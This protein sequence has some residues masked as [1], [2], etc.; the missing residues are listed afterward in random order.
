MNKRVKL[1]LVGVVAL[2]I[3]ASTWAFFSSESKIEN[4]LHTK[5]YGAETIEKFQPEQEL[6]P[7]TVIIKEVGVKNT[8]DYDLVVRVKLE[9]EWIRGE[10]RVI[11]FD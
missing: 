2:V 9:E 4:K 6:E 7:G 1:A 8:G 10:D 3:I 11:A 5:E